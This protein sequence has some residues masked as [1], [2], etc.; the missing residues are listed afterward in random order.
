M[1]MASNASERSRIYATCIRLLSRREYGRASLRRKLQTKGYDATLSEEVLDQLIAS[2]LQSDARCAAAIIRTGG[3]RGWSRRRCRSRMIQEGLGEETI[4]AA[5]WP[6]D[7]DERAAARA[8]Y[9][10]W[11]GNGPVD[12]KKRRRV[13]QRLARRGFSIGFLLDDDAPFGDR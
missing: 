9:L 13:L 6:N 5:P 12:A 4:S 1:T 2:D 3:H 11:L 10:K 8:L 7:D